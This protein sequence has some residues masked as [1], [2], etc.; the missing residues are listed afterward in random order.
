[1]RA[2]VSMPRRLSQVKS[3]AKKIAQ[4]KY[5]TCG[6]KF[7]AALLHQMPLAYLKLS[8]AHARQPMS[9]GMRQNLHATIERAHG[10]GLKVI[11]IERPPSPEEAKPLEVEHHGHG[12][13]H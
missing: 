11:G 8:A 7:C 10:A 2:E 3:A 9:D 4:A 5:G 12:G 13:H 1:M 6:S